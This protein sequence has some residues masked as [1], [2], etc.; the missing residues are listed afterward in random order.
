MVKIEEKIFQDVFITEVCDVL[1][2]LWLDGG[3]GAVNFVK[4]YIFKKRMGLDLLKT[5]TN[6]GVTQYVLKL[7]VV[8]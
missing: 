5:K 4:I 3:S 1:W 7:T 2:D 8:L 6:I